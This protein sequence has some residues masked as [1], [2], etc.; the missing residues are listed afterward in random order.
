[1]D[2]V[3]VKRNINL[4]DNNPSI[5]ESLELDSV[6]LV[7][8]GSTGDLAKRKVFPALYNL[9][10]DGKIPDSF[11]VIGLGRREW[12]NNVFQTHV[13][14]S[15]TTF[16]RRLPTDHSKMERFIQAFQYSTLDVNNDKEYEKLLEMIRKNEEELNIPEN[17][18]FYLSVAPQLFDAITMNIKKSGLSSTKGWKR[19]IIEKPFGEDLKSAQQ[20]NKKLS[21]AF[22]EDEIYRID[23]YLGKS[24]IQNLEALKFANPVIKALWNNQ[25]I[26]NVQITASETVGIENRADF[27]EQSGAI[28]DMVQ[29]HMLQMLMMTAVHLP[30][31]NSVKSIRKEKRKIMES[32]QAFQIEEINS[33]VV[34][35]QYDSGEILG[36]SVVGYTEEQEVDETSKTDTFFAARVQIEDPFWSGVPFYI[37]T[38][39]RMKEKSTRIVI[40]FKKPLKCAYIA[41]REELSP[42]I[43]IIEVSPNEGVFFQLNSRNPLKG[44]EIEPIIVEFSTSQKEIPEAYELLLFDALQ[45]DQT[46]FAH[47]SELELSWKWIQP[48]LEAFKEDILPLHLYPS[49]STGPKA[50]DQLL[51]KDGFTWW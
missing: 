32:L 34:R 50:A 8:F 26:A 27:Y 33:H 46:F 4:E 43:L 47:W 11:S 22:E 41:Q 1:M 36:E 45:G 30:K 38:G 9:F 6:T 5:S 13:K 10:L 12:S 40:E 20:L 23:H 42:N 44:G 16:S 24:M 28:R 31:H 3:A 2:G 25:H 17:R 35:G 21:V 29:N 37:R 14:E 19:L 7:L 51:E 15:L 39:K 48:I 49:G 18:L